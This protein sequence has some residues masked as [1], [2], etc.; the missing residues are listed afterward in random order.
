MH[1]SSVIRPSDLDWL[2]NP[3]ARGRTLPFATDLFG[4]RTD[5]GKPFYWAM[6]IS[7]EVGGIRVS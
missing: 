4:A 3:I 2:A 6:D 7:R 5:S 1:E